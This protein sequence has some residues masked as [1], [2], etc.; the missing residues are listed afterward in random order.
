MTKR[1]TI[2]MLSIATVGE[3]AE[4]DTTGNAPLAD[5][6]QRGDKVAVTSLLKQRA[7]VNAP[8]GDGATALH[9]ATYLNDAETTALL[10]KAGANINARNNLGVTP[11]ALAAEQGNATIIQQLM[12]AGADPDDPVNYV[13]AP[14]TPLMHAA[15]AGSVDAVNTFMGA[16]AKINA[17]E[18]WN[19]QSALMWAAAEGHSAV[20]QALIDGGAD[21]YARS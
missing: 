12:K 3:A 8:H 1:F 6:V 18:T 2:L 17:R 4:V 9:W 13:D 19:G 14:E 11:L 5:A 7:D 16:G 10:L 20:V 21:I 15:R